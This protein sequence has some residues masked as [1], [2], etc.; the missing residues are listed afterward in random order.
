MPLAIAMMSGSTPVHSISEELSRTANAGL[1]FVEDEKQAALIAK[2][3][4][5]AQKFRRRWHEP[6]FPLNGFDQDCGRSL[7]DRRSDCAKI[8]ERHL[9]EALHFRAE[10]LE[11][12]RLPSSRDGR[13]RPAVKSPFEG[14][15]VR[16]RSPSPRA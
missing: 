8:A 12:F 11:V 15:L 13:Q 5:R 14:D 6:P 4:Q 7:G 1:H 3:T 9:V 16:K 10:A 2:A